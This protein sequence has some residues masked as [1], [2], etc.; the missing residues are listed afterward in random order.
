MTDFK[1]SF[2]PLAADNAEV[3]ILGSIPGDRS[4]ELD[5]Y[6]AHPQNRF[7]R[8]M[9]IITDSGLSNDYESRKEM[10][11][12]NRIALWDVAAQAS[13]KGSMDSEIRDE[14]PNMID[15][16][17]DRHPDLRIVAFNG[18][19]AEQLYDR[20]FA[21]RAGVVYLS[22]PSTSPANAV[23]RLDDLCRLWGA[24][25]EGAI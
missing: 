8:V 17:I 11:I 16:F 4:I 9:A 1:E 7:W 12:R 5:Q 14:I 22:L 20:Y 2:E 3:L 18:R 6:Y 15:D 23:F 10:L 19:K 21:R 13:R 25:F 24:I